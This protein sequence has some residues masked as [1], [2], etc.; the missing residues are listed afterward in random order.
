MNRGRAARAL[1][2]L[3]FLSHCTPLSAQEWTRFR[4]PN[5]TGLSDAA[6]VPATWTEKDYNW[7]VTLPGL[8]HSQPVLWGEKIF[9]TSALEKGHRRLVLCVSAEDG[10]VLWQRQISSKTHGKHALNSF[11]SSTPAV[12]AERVYVVFA[13]PDEQLLIAFDHSGNESWRHKLGS[14]VS[15]HGQGT[16][17]ILFEDLVILG[18]EQGQG[19]E[20]GGDRAASGGGASSAGD[21]AESY[22]LALERA[23]GKLRWKTPRET[24]RVSYSTPCV[25]LPK[26]GPAQVIFNSL[27]HGITSVDARTGAPLWDAK[28]FTMR[29]CSSPVIAGGIV[30]GTCGSGGGGNYLVAVRAGGNGDVLA[31]HEAYRLDDAIPYVPTPLVKGD[32]VFTFSDRVAVASCFEAS[33]G[34]T[35]WQQRVGLQFWASPVCVADRIYGVARDGQVLV[36]AAADEY[37]EIARVSLGEPSHTTPAVAGGRIYFRTFSERDDCTHLISLGGK[38]LAA[39]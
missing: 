32:R 1:L 17:P 26:D 5:G 13:H 11:A 39:N 15:Q 28:C 23:T 4:G 36:I 31:T 33:T 8:G 29:T 38:K 34:K 21:A 16:S 7:R 24:A 12:D 6:T 27:A 20:G 14:F 25:Y 35:V 3:L 30:L 22:L 9:L 2:S 37:R 10:S 19:R 18:N